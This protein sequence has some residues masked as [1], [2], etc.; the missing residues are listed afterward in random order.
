[1]SD[2]HKNSA[3]GA[4]HVYCIEKVAVVGNKCRSEA[5]VTFLTEAVAP[6]TVA[7][8]FPYE[9]ALRL[10]EMAGDPPDPSLPSIAPVMAKIAGNKVPPHTQILVDEYGLEV[11]EAIR[12]NGLFTV[13]ARQASS[14]LQLPLP[15]EERLVI[16]NAFVAGL[17][18]PM[19]VWWD[20]G[21]VLFTPSFID[22][23][24]EKRRSAVT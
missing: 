4:S 8:V 12:L 18:G 14:T 19:G 17:N 9:E 6:V 13:M 15:S 10:A 2:L 16:E 21:K 22:E 1:M 23:M 3:T 20:K 7:G 5:E 24:E 11:E